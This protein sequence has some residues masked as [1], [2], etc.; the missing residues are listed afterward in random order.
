MYYFI[1]CLAM[2]DL[3]VSVN[4][5]LGRQSCCCWRLVSWPPG[6]AVVQLDNALTCSSAAQVSSLCFLGAIAVDAT[7][8]SSTPCRYHSVVTLPRAWRIIAA[9]WVASIL[10]SVLSITYYNHT[11]VLLCLVGFFIAML[12]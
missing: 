7:S 10:T 9:I 11:V 12:A 1:C 3:L 4:C 2:S 8:P 6:P 5:V